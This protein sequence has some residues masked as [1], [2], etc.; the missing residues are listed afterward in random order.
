METTMK[1]KEQK[2]RQRKNKKEKR[3]K[4]LE[5]HKLSA[6]QSD[7]IKINDKWVL[8]WKEITIGDFIGP[9]IPKPIAETRKE[10]FKWNL[11]MF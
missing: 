7:F 1:M 5:N 2:K 10:S 8:K 3:K 4:I 9:S 11:L 6:E